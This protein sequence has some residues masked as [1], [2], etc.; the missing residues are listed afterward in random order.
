MAYYRP[1]YVSYTDISPFKVVAWTGQ[2]SGY[3]IQNG[4]CMSTFSYDT[5]TFIP[6]KGLNSQLQFSKDQKIYIEFSISPN[7]QV[8]GASIKCTT[9]NTQDNWKGYPNMIEISPSDITNQDGT[10]KT[11]VDGK[12]Q[13]K[14]YA[15]IAYRQDDT[16]KNGPNSPAPKSTSNSPVQILNNDIIMMASI[17]SGVPIVFP[18]PF[19][20]AN[21]HTRAIQK[22]L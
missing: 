12:R 17:M 9:V 18:C 10:I 16:S 19:Y 21:S 1:T 2:G 3:M 6:L 11:V 14:C 4:T 20:G 8:S 15:L 7:L 13:V 22:D 5:G